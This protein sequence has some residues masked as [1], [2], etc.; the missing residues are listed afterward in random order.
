[1]RGSRRRAREF[2][3][4]FV[5]VG[6]LLG[7]ITVHV[8]LLSFGAI[9]FVLKRNAVAGLAAV[10]DRPQEV[11]ERMR[12]PQQRSVLRVLS[13][14]DRLTATGASIELTQY[15]RSSV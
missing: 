14:L 10:A 1:G 11:A 4:F 7:M 8:P 3:H 13:F 9:E 15:R 5:A 6:V 2:S 12:R